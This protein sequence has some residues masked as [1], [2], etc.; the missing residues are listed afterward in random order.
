MSV[1]DGVYLNYCDKPSES[2][3]SIAERTK[4]RKQRSDEIAKEGKIIDRKLFEK[5]FGYLSPSDMCKNLNET[6]A[7][8]KTRYK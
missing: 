7:Q 1:F 8:K 5:Y 6:T 4:S 2:E 3:E